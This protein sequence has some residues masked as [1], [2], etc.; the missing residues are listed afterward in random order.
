MKEPEQ[1]QGIDEIDEDN[2]RDNFIGNY[3]CIKNYEAESDIYIDL[4]AGDIVSISEFSGKYAIGFNCRTE[5]NGLFPIYN[6]DSLNGFAIFYR[7]IADSEDASKNDAIFVVSEAE[8]DLLLGY[9][10]T[11]EDTGSFHMDQLEVLQ[12]DNDNNPILSYPDEQNLSALPYS[13]DI[14]YTEDIYGNIDPS[15]MNYANSNQ[16][17]L[18]YI[19]TTTQ[20]NLTNY[21][22]NNYYTTNQE[23][24]SSLNNYS[25]QE[26]EQYDH[27]MSNN[28][29]LA[30]SKIIKNINNQNTS[31]QNSLDLLRNALHKFEKLIQKNTQDSSGPTSSTSSTTITSRRN[32]KVTATNHKR[33]KLIL[34]ELIGKEDEFNQKL[35]STIYILITSLEKLINTP[36]EILSKF[37]INSFFKYFPDI[38]SF[39]NKILKDLR[40]GLGKYDERGLNYICDIFAKNFMNCIVYLEYQADYENLLSYLENIKKDKERLERINKIMKMNE[41]KFCRMRFTDL[42]F[43]VTQHFTSYKL[44]LE[45]IK[46][47]VYEDDLYEALE[48]EIQYLHTIGL[49]MDK[50]EHENA[51]IRKFFALKSQIMNFPP[52]FLTSKRKLISEYDITE[53]GRP[54]QKHIYLFNDCLMVVTTNKEATRKG[55]IY[56]LENIINL[57]DYEFNKVDQGT[58]SCIRCICRSHNNDIQIENP[59]RS[60]NNPNRLSGLFKYSKGRKP[61]SKINFLYFTNM[62]ECNKFFKECRLQKYN[63]EDNNIIINAIN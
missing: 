47:S 1:Y 52:T 27:Q 28:T 23:L 33:I 57:K 2:S 17:A 22:D 60:S 31:H 7:V 55:Y 61:Q 46:K 36:D 13:N 26:Y 59:I 12:F 11:K 29:I 32:K 25:V 43:T 50:T 58:K 63:T 44:I 42:F 30:F 8:N 14:Y 37:E 9:N 4:E 38:Y 56:S 3:I 53:N 15:N 39:S 54:T 5:S 21:Y 6:I 20:P 51:Q 41:S 48:S 24:G 18:A 40:E 45:D 19:G 49:Y 16:S 10:I 34:K 62:A 35:K